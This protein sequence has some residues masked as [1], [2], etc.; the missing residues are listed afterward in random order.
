MPTLE[1][2]SDLPVLPSLAEETASPG[3]ADLNLERRVEERTAGLQAALDER[4][5]IEAKLRASEE[6][7][8][9][10][11]QTTAISIW[12]EDFSDLKAALDELRAQGVSDLPRYLDEN[13][14]FL[15]RAIQLIRIS[16]VNDATLRLFEAT[17]KA[18]LLGSLERIFVP[19][20]LNVFRQELLA[21]FEGRP[22]VEGEA[23][24]RT[25]KGRSLRVAFS[26]SADPRDSELRS[27]LVSLTDITECRQAE[28]KAKLLAR[29]VNH[30]A[31]NLLTVM[32]AMMRQT[33][34][35]TVPEF[36][37]SMQGRINAL[38][39]VQTRLARDQKDRTSLLK[40]IDEELAPFAKDVSARFSIVG[41]DVP[42]G[43]EAAQALAITIHELAT[44]AVKYGSLSVPVGRVAIEWASSGDE[45]TLSWSESCGP[46]THK[47]SREGFGTRA[48][49][50]LSMKLGGTVSTEWRR[51]G[52]VCTLAIPMQSLES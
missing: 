22:R 45:L 12:D 10:I 47:P 19:D 21:V 8:R 30:R 40:L 44:N 42:L 49:S 51:H 38:A 32:S 34:A 28:E 3:R 18:E 43:P 2:Q 16:D 50:L 17:D 14:G 27:V 33:R 1:R 13:P 35:E 20:T 6:R 4:M 5:R 25:L 36:I 9:R 31:N 39:R 26:M 46:P 24:L 48:I 37:S 52:L 7:Y 29:E 23:P 11:F 15:A 41:P